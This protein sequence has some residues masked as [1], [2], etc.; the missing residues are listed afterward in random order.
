MPDN[1]FVVSNCLAPTGRTIFATQ[2]LATDRR[3]V[4][5][6]HIVDAKA[7]QRLCTVTLDE[8]EFR[9]LCAIPGQSQAAPSNNKQQKPT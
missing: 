7:N 9:R 1:A 6:K 8:S 5:W 2:V 4:L 3:D